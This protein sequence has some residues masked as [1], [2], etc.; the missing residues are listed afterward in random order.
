MKK[1]K[2]T[3]VYLDM[4]GVLT[5]FKEG[6]YREFGQP[7]SYETESALW[8]FWNDFDKVVTHDQVNAICN[9]NFWWSLP[10]MPDGRD[11]A[12]KVLEKFGFHTYLLSDPM[13]NVESMTGK[14]KWV[15]KHLPDLFNQTILMKA[16]K[17]LL[18]NDH[19]LLIDDRDQNIERFQK[20]GGHGI[21]VP[22]PGN[23]MSEFADLSV[24]IVGLALRKYQLV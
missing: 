3:T 15:R 18:A 21:L 2:I 7:Y 8:D 20:A 10:W 17:E 11:I 19:T 24:E 5:N 9:D 12:G 13:P 6:V 4:D 1:I 23:K 14:W 16:P 22:R